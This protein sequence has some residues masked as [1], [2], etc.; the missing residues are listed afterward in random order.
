MFFVIELFLT[1][2]S[3]QFLKNGRISINQSLFFSGKKFST[4]LLI[5]I[6]KINK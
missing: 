4:T 6:L 2:A 1:V 5:P 3:Y